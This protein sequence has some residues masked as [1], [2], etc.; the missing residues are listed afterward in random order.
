MNDACTASERLP[1]AADA[2]MKAVAD[3]I[4][5]IMKTLWAVNAAG[6]ECGWRRIEEAIM[7]RDEV[8]SGRGIA[9]EY[10]HRYDTRGKVSV[11]GLHQRTSWSDT[12]LAVEVVR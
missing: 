7:A 1:V 11:V 9:L 2:R 3:R 12:K 4:E 5:S 10:S 6:G 8:T